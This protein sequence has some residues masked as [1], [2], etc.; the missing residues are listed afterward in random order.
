MTASDL[1]SPLMERKTA[2]ATVM[3]KIL[4]DNDN[5]PQFS[6]RTYTVSISEDTWGDNNVVAHI[7]ASDA[8]QG[9]NAA[10]RFAIIGGNTQSQFAIDSLSGDVTLVKQ[11]DYE[12]VRT[13]R[14]VVRAQDGGSPSKSNTTQ[15]L[16]NVLDA[17]DN[18]P[19]QVTNKCTY[20]EKY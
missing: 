16:V 11:L 1:A 7:T 6:E 10:I 12:S 13:Y 9:N 14:L 19:R 3:V 15:L 2:T 20:D 8:D 17:N 5:Y 18:A 4:D